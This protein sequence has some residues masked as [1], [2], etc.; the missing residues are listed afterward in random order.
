MFGNMDIIKNEIEEI[1]RELQRIGEMRPGLL[2]RQGPKRHY[3]LSYTYEMKSRTEYVR[4][5]FVG[6]L[7]AQVKTFKRFKRLI[8]KWTDLALE[9]SR[10]KIWMLKGETN[11]EKIDK[12]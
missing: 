5:E 7:K 8:K 11:V 12:S 9:H 3:Q 6:L 1:K 4:P 10:L 2:S